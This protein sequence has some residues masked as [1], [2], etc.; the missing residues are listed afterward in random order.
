LNSSNT[1][2]FNFSRGFRAPNVAELGSN[3]K[4][5]GS[6]R[7]EIG[8]ATLRS[9]V[10]HQIDLAFF[11]NSDHF[12]LELTP[13]INFIS[14]YI[15]VQKMVDA[16]GNG[17]IPD[18]A[19]PAPAF[20][21]VQG[22]A[23]LYGGEVYVDLHPHPLDWL[24]LENSF[25]YVRAKQNNRPTAQTN[26]P[27]IPAPKYRSEIRAQFKKVGKKLTNVYAKWLL[28]TFLRKTTFL[29]PTIPKL[30][31]PVTHYWAQE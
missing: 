23:T 29:R 11:H 4:H 10:S 8:E 16:D 3:G 6:F 9:E 26:L 20:K 28:I 21:Y 24:H 15:F 17:I 2:K 19:D 12:T 30:Q 27:L 22:N 25:S 14:N 7:Y 1:L 31:H 13:Y 18:P 5:E